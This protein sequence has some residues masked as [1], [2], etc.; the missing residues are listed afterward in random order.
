[1]ADQA[2]ITPSAID[3][4][5]AAFFKPI[6]AGLIVAMIGQGLIIWR[7]SAIMTERWQAM[8]EIDSMQT[9][10]L[11]ALKDA[12]DIVPLLHERQQMQSERL[13]KHDQLMEWLSAN[14]QTQQSLNAEQQHQLSQ[15]QKEIMELRRTLR[16]DPGYP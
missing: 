15:C 16:L 6:V 7:Q 4:W 11:V 3:R 13:N 1:V 5:M 14:L 12:F 8:R 2:P 9:G 10:R